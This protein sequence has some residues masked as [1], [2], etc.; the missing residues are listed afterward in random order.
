MLWHTLWRSA[1]KDSNGE[2]VFV[3]REGDDDDEVV[4]VENEEEEEGVV[5][6][7][8]GWEKRVFRR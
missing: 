6:L 1:W 7:V 5:V 8:I 2:R 4:E 3:L